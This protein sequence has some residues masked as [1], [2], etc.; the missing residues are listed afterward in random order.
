MGCFVVLSRRQR[1]SVRPPPPP[2]P[3]RPDTFV[4]LQVTFAVLTCPPKHHAIAFSVATAATGGCV[5]KLGLG[6]LLGA[7]AEIFKILDDPLGDR[8]HVSRCDI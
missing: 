8:C 3:L 4:P 6:H 7:P 5:L 2:P 1:A